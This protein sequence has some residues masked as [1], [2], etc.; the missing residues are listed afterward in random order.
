MKALI[1]F[2]L[3]LS[4][5]I[6]I[7][8]H[9]FF[10]GRLVSKNDTIDFFASI[11][12]GVINT[13]ESNH[14]RPININLKS[15]GTESTPLF[16]P[17]SSFEFGVAYK[18][19]IPGYKLGFGYELLASSL[20]HIESSGFVFFGKDSILDFLSIRAGGFTGVYIDRVFGRTKYSAS[21]EIGQYETRTVFGPE[22]A[23]SLRLGKIS[24]LGSERVGFFAGKY[25][26]HK[27]SLYLRVPRI[28]TNIGIIHEKNLGFKIQKYFR[29]GLG[30]S[31]QM[32]IVKEQFI[33]KGF[34][35]TY[36]FQ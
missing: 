13:K 7:S 16:R 36:S 20:D 22:I 33:S 6:V 21:S 1:T 10:D 12:F 5:T 4:C 30:I 15:S 29:C 26:D 8:Q 23:F 3:V 28:N 18:R 9:Q 31:G 19:V 27:S 14:S 11:S 32:F 24:L 25:L 34:G 17:S 35:V 2:I